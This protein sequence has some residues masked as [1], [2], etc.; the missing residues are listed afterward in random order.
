MPPSRIP[1]AGDVKVSQTFVDLLCQ[2]LA[3]QVWWGGG[4]WSNEELLGAIQ[5]P[6]DS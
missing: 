6:R 3:T 4:C 1:M 5:P 2:R